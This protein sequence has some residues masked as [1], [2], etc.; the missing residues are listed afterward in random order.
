MCPLQQIACS[1]P[2]Y[3]W[4]LPCLR[5]GNK[6]YGRTECRKTLFTIPVKHEDPSKKTPPLANYISY[7]G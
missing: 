7:T 6:D 1:L 5:T 4:P 3:L 2:Y